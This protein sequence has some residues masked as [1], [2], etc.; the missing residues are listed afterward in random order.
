MAKGV[1]KAENLGAY[2]KN[3]SDSDIVTIGN[4]ENGKSFDSIY[5]NLKKVYIIINL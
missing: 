4:A 2:T 3:A 5:E 1:D